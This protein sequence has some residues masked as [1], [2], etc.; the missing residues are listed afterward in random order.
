M[1]NAKIHWN[2]IFAVG[3]LIPTFAK[4]PAEKGLRMLESDHKMERATES[5]ARSRFPEPHAIFAHQE[6][7]ERQSYLSCYPLVTDIRET[8]MKLATMVFAGALAFAS[9]ISLA[10]AAGAGGAAGSAGA[11]S[12]GSMS[13][14]STTAPPA[15][16]APG[17]TTGQAKPGAMGSPGMSTNPSGNSLINTSP[18]GSTLD[19]TGTGS[20]TRR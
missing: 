10:Q 3:S 14:S 12:T 18:S 17:A 9:S 8:P 4:V 15:G 20:G 16:S 7:R 6:V 11:S 1:P 13:G 2:P 19:Q 5:F